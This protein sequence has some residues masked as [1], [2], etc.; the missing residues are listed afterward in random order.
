M[1]T[2]ARQLCA[3][4]HDGRVLT[5]AARRIPSYGEDRR[6][7][8]LPERAATCGDPDRPVMLWARAGPH[9]QRLLAVG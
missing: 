7:T 2:P 1:P 3:L 4:L 9:A 5:D 6:H 8:P